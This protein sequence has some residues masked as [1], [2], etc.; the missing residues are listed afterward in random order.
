MAFIAGTFGVSYDAAT[1]GITSGGITIEHYVNKQLIT[2]DNKG[3]T[4]QDAVYQGE[5]VF[6]QF[7]CIEADNAK[8]KL[9]MWPYETATG[10]GKLGVIGRT[11]VGSAIFKALVLSSTAATPAA[12]QPAT[13]TA[14]RAILAEGFPVAM[15]FGPSLRDIPL[16]FRLYPNAS[17]L[18]YDYALS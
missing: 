7:T 13:F 15:V 10:L 17:D 6:V 1:I 14:E 5:E 4:P 8:L 18:F 9:A 11:D 12:A 16:R 3:L 2:G